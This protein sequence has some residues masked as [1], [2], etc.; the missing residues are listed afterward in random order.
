MNAHQKII[1]DNVRSILK[2][3]TNHYGVKYSAALYQILKEHPDFPSFLSFQYILHRMG[4]DSFAIHTSYEEL[5]NMPAPFIVHGVTNVDLFLFITKATAESVQII[6]EKGKE[7]S[8]KKEDFE[9]M[10]DGNIL[11][12]D[13]LPGKINIPSKSKLDLF[14]KLAK[15]PF[16]ILCLVALC[17]YSLILKGVGDIL[18]YVYLLVLLGGLGTSILLFIEQIDKYNV[19]IKRLCSSNGSKSN[20]DCSSILDFK[21]RP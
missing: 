11:I 6:D 8:I 17:T 20:I 12:I 10:W 16:L 5:T 13:N 15:Y 1:K 2:I 9:K 19:H 21:E 3:I 4:K 7:E 18:F 14:I